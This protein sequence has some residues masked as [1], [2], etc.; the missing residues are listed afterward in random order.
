LD[1]SDDSA[2]V[3]RF[4]ETNELTFKYCRLCETVI[5]HALA[6]EADVEPAQTAINDHF[7]SKSHLRK[8]ESLSIKEVED[9]AFALLDFHSQPGDITSELKKE[10]EKALKRKVKK[11]KMQI[12]NCAVSHENA[13]TYPGK[14]LKSSNKN[15]LQIRC[16]E[17]E[18]SVFPVIKNYDTVEA[19]LNDVIRVLEKRG[20]G[21]L[22]L[23]RKLKFIPNLV[24]ITKRVQI[25][26]K[27]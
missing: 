12:L 18:M 8:R 25:C 20:A 7:Q 21:D 11:L 2:K 24:D 22:H 16:K 23:M 15:R 6:S 26:P 4:L 1:G 17:L 27:G 13:S 9:H 19:I 10:K 14:E 5:H 3:L